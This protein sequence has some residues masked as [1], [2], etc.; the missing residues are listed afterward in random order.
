[1]QGNVGRET[2][3]HSSCTAIHSHTCIVHSVMHHELCVIYVA[4][5]YGFNGQFCDCDCFTVV[6]I[7]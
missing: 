5:Q 6:S 7:T 1:M 4:N 3:S 2:M